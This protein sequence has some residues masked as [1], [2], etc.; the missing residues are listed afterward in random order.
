MRIILFTGKGGVG[1]TTIAAATALKAAELGYKTLIISTDVAHSLADAL[2]TTLDNSPRAVGNSNLYAAEIDTTEELERHW[3]DIK[4]KVANFLKEQG[5]EATIAGELAVIPG[6]DEILSLVR[7]H[8]IFSEDVFDLL[9][10]DSA[11]TGAAMRLLSAPD[12]NQFYFPD[13]TDIKRGIGRLLK[14][15]LMLLKKLPFSENE[16]REKFKQ[17]A[18]KVEELHD[19]LVNPQITSVRL[20]LNPERMALLETERAFTYFALYGLN[21]D[22]VLVNRLIPEQVMDPYLRSWKESQAHYAEKIHHSFAPLP[23]FEIPLLDREI[24]DVKSLNALSKGI[25]AEHD[26]AKLLTEEKPLQF[27][28][29]DDRYILKLRIVGVSGSDIDLQKEGDS[30]KVKVGNYSRSI[31]LPAYISGLTPTSATIDGKTLTIIFPT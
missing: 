26:P 31:A 30:L 14:P 3:G 18:G 4:R 23:V 10:I 13:L 9:I 27:F 22:A 17:L 16:F 29:E 25:Y 6:L 8:K 15:S 21:V 24:A 28:S 2:N 12:L 7:I 11:P 20:V 5:M 1:K 19:I